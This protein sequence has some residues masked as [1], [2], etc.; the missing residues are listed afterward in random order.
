M[1]LAQVCLVML[2]IHLVNMVAKQNLSQEKL[3]RK[4]MRQAVSQAWSKRV[5]IL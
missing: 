2:A 3:V 5:H 4:I 1:G